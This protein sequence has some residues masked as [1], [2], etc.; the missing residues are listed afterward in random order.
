MKS[1]GS[2]RARFTLAAALITAIAVLAGVLVLLGVL[3]RSLISRIDDELLER[4]IDLTFA[5]EDFGYPDPSLLPF[6]EDLVAAVFDSDD[7]VVVDNIFEDFTAEELLTSLPAEHLEVIT[8]V[9]EEGSFTVALGTDRFARTRTPGL[10]GTDIGDQYWVYLGRSLADVDSTVATARNWAI[11]AGP[12]LVLLIAGLTWLLTGRTLRR[13]DRMRA[14]V[15]ELRRTTNLAQRLEEPKRGDELGHLATTMNE[16]LDQLEANDRRQ[17]QFVSDA[18]HELRTPLASINA[19]IDVDLAHPGTADWPATA[20]SVR[21]ETTRLQRLIDDL[22]GLARAEQG[23][24]NP[25]R[26][27][28]DV[29]DIIYSVASKGSEPSAAVVD[30]SG[31]APVVVRGSADQLTRV[32]ENLLANANR[33]ARSRINVTLE[34]QGQ[35]AVLT[36]GDDGNGVA[37]NDREAVFERF[38]RLDEARSSDAGGAGLGLALTREI[39]AGHN[40]SIAVGESALGGALFTVCLPLVAD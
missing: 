33:H 9:G 31:V 28:V 20:V 15:D 1:L 21:Q 35:H 27:L 16:M 5:I 32:V 19:Q 8:L 40:G 26:S 30:V 25:R 7:E 38:V 36:V 6:E 39:V 12:L 13:V 4:S 3:E 14:E 11:V 18:A 22:L 24:S 10:V 23:K 34:E 2:I 37:P 29:D 17:K